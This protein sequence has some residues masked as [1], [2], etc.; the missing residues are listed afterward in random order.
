MKSPS[1]IRK[2]EVKKLGQQN[3]SK[4][5]KSQNISLQERL[6]DLQEVH[7]KALEEAQKRQRDFMKTML[8]EQ[9]QMDAVEREKDRQFL[10][11]L[12]N[13]FAQK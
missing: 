11:Q 8:E 13:L 1:K 4:S 9:R 3:P 12:R 2:S 6:V 7:M 5:R 10:L